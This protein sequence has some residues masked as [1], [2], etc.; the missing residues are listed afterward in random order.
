[1]L[2]YTGSSDI[3]LDYINLSVKS[4]TYFHFNIIFLLAVYRV[5]T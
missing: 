2:I 3:V 5:I 1:V 4:E